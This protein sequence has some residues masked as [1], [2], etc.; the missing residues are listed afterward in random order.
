MG[1]SPPGGGK[2]P[3][4]SHRRHGCEGRA[5]AGRFRGHQRGA[6]EGGCLGAYE[7]GHGRL[8]RNGQ[9]YW[10]LPRAKLLVFHGEPQR[11]TGGIQCFPRVQGCREGSSALSGQQCMKVS[12]DYACTVAGGLG[13][14]FFVAGVCLIMQQGHR[15]RASIAC[16]C[17]LGH[18][19]WLSLAVCVFLLAERLGWTSMSTYRPLASFLAM[20]VMD[21]LVLAQ[22]DSKCLRLA[23]R[24]P[25]G[26]YSL[27]HS[28]QN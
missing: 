26:S 1:G 10:R 27:E 8:Q 14:Q 4:Q 12:D 18:A 15:N 5:V 3:C 25:T 16:A 23:F 2:G 13:G 20:C 19:S 22:E 28:V 17:A 21:G 6:R 24:H 11:C 7:Q 9:G